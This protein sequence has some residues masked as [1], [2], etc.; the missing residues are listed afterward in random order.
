MV[1]RAA[2]AG[3]GGGVS[4]LYPRPEWQDH[5]DEP[6]GEN[7]RLTPDISAVSDPDTGVNIAFGQR[8]VAGG[9]TP[10]PPRI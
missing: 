3:T 6:T 4:N 9:G 8:I 5:I 10:W 1:R 2:V 7:R